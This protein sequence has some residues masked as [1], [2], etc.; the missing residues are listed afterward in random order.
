MTILAG[1]FMSI[2]MLIVSVFMF[3][4]LRKLDLSHLFTSESTG[5]ISSTKFWTNISYFVATVAFLT[6]N[7][8]APGAASLEMIWLIYLGVVASSAS[9]SKLLALRFKGG[10]ITRSEVEHRTQTVSYSD[11]GAH[12]S[13]QTPPR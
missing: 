2:I 7:I 4:G 11:S 10:G 1:V 5:Q 3:N 6:V 8:F 9:V 12:P 13:E